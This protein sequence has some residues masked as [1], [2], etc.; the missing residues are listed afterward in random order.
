MCFVIWSGKKR[1]TESNL[2]KRIFMRKNGLFHNVV[3]NAIQN[4]C[5]LN[6]E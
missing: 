1:S 6:D 5:G 2:I 3:F 4:M